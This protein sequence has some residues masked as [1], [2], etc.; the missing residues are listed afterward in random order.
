M[1]P[2]CP[3]ATCSSAWSRRPPGWPSCAA[4]RAR[5]ARP[6]R[7]PLRRRRRTAASATVAGTV[8]AAARAG[9][10]AAAR[11]RRAQR[12]ARPRRPVSLTLDDGVDTAVV[13]ALL[14]VG[15]GHRH[16]TDHVRHRGVRVVDRQ[17]RSAAAAGR[18]GPD[19][20]GQPHLDPPRPHQAEPAPGRRRAAAHR[21]VHPRHLR[22]RRRRR[23]TGRPTAPT[24]TWSSRWPPTSATPRPPCGTATSGDDQILAPRD[25]VAN[26]DKY[27]VPQ[28]VVIGHL[29]H[30]PVTSV[31]REL[32]DIIHDRRL[33]TVT[34]NDVF[35]KPEAT[36]L[37]SGLSRVRLSEPQARQ[38]QLSVH[39]CASGTTSANRRWRR[40]AICASCSAGCA[41]AAGSRRP[42]RT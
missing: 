13:R 37:I 18:V 19:P 27:Y 40:R 16:P 1:G 38:F 32:V 31:Y 5:R 11:R 26:A 8:A 20:A 4:A 12:A 34:L 30:P 28:S 7:S 25:I 15:Q 35:D 9:A 23:T 36:R 10:D 22:R 21:P 14:P 29:N 41:A 33:R 2:C 42:P 17:P 24:T 3:A 39:S 6:R